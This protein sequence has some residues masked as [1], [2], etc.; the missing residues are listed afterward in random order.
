MYVIRNTGTAI[1]PVVIPEVIL[2]QERP[3][4]LLTNEDPNDTIL[5][6]LP[7][8]KQ[9]NINPNLEIYVVTTPNTGGVIAVELENGTNSAGIAD[10]IS[11][12]VVKPVD[13]GGNVWTACP[14]SVV[15]DLPQEQ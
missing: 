2:S 5:Y 8:L 3:V 11:G 7:D 15:R 12:L 6:Q 14:C 4:V 9:L 1:I 10:A 13:Q